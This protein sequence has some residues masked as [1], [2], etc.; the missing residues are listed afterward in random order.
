MGQRNTRGS[1]ISADLRAIQINLNNSRR[2]HDLLVTTAKSRKVQIALIS[3]P[4]RSKGGGSWYEAVDG[5]AAILVVDNT[6]PVKQLARGTGY[7][8][9]LAGRV[10]MTSCYLSQRP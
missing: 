10:E 6:L 2:A 8:T 4:S 9:I 1:N 7:V 3:E 5:K